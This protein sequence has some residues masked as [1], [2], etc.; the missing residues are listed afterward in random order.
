MGWEDEREVKD[1]EDGGEGENEGVR[2]WF[3][4]NGDVERGAPLVME[5]GGEE[6]DEEDNKIE[7][8]EVQEE[9]LK[10]EEDE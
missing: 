6:E 7:L 2:V 1:D 8:E 5:E 4:E 10:K 9:G 3:V